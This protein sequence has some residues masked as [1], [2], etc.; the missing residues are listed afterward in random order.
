MTVIKAGRLPVSLWKDFILG[1]KT[2]GAHFFIPVA[3]SQNSSLFK[4]SPRRQHLLI[5]TF[6]L[7]VVVLAVS[8]L[9]SFRNKRIIND[10]TLNFIF[11]TLLPIFFFYFEFFL[12]FFYLSIKNISASAFLSSSNFTFFIQSIKIY[13]FVCD[14]NSEKKIISWGINRSTFFI[15]CFNA[16]WLPKRHDALKFEMKLKCE[17]REDKNWEKNVREKNGNVSFNGISDFKSFASF[18]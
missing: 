5:K 10:Q 15:N 9:S 1:K 7:P 8:A 4:T 2:L 16:E 18:I 6:N 14:A 13:F 11:Y 17:N 12:F 3:A